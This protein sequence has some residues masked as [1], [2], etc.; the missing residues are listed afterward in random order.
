MEDG[1]DR[2]FAVLHDDA[3][4]LTGLSRLLDWHI[5]RSLAQIAGL[6]MRL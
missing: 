5:G 4:V 2:F 3:R 6:D 1:G